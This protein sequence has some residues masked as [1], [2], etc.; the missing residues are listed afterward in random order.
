MDLGFLFSEEDKDSSLVSI[1]PGLQ[2]LGKKDGAEES[3]VDEAT[4]SRPYLSEAWSGLERRKKEDSL[5]NWRIPAL[6]NEMDMKDNLKWRPHGQRDNIKMK[7]P[8]FRDTSSPEEYLEWVQRVDK[9]FEYR[10]YNEVKK[11]KL[12][13]IKF[14]D[15]ANLWW[16]N[17]K[18]QRR[19]DG[20]DDVQTW[21]EIK[22]S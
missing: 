19:R 7:I 8:T 2:R 4:I 15:Y 22:E 5:M 16:E 1:I 18:A 3:R 10:E 14:I 9:I 17:V 21:H 6:S 12:A 13:A 20:L 11:C